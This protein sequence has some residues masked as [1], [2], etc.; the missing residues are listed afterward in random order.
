MG[1]VASSTRRTFEPEGSRADSGRETN[2][3]ESHGNKIA[4][5]QKTIDDFRLERGVKGLAVDI[6]V[7]VECKEQNIKTDSRYM[8]S[9]QIADSQSQTWFWRSFPVA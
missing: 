5:E 9:E 1:G 7:H 8:D 4:D 2:C 3:L 6:H